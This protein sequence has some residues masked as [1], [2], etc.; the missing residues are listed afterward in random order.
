MNV[1]IRDGPQAPNSKFVAAVK[2]FLLIIFYSRVKLLLLYLNVE[3][4]RNNY[5]KNS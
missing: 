2:Y 3:L 5:V 1:T 4:G